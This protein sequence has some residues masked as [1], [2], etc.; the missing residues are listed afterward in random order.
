MGLQVETWGP[1]RSSTLQSSLGCTGFEQRFGIDY[2]ENFASVVKPMSYKA[3][4]ALV[5]ALD[6]ELEQMDVKT[7][8]LYG[9]SMK[10]SSWNSQLVKRTGQAGYA[11]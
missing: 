7:A 9:P 3:F 10:S 11:A 6:W 8:F 4:S 2:L 1:R 5:A